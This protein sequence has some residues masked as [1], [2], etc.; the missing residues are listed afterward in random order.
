MCVCV[1]EMQGANLSECKAGLKGPHTFIM[2]FPI[3]AISSS[4][5]F[6]LARQWGLLLQPPSLLKG[7]NSKNWYSKWCWNRKMVQIYNCAKFLAVDYW[8][9]ILIKL[10]LFDSRCLW[11]VDSDCADFRPALE[12]GN[13]MERKRRPDVWQKLRTVEKHAFIYSVAEIV[14]WSMNYSA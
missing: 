8:R 6:S 9:K 4:H 1:C 10:L 12:T 5:V 14:G 11:N 13:N 3:S 2:Y 7:N